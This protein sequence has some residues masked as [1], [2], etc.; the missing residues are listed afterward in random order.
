L[1]LAEECFLSRETIRRLYFE[2]KNEPRFSGLAVQTGPTTI[3]D[4]GPSQAPSLLKDGG[5]SVQAGPFN[6]RIESVRDKS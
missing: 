1:Q 5:V 6:L 2:A 4:E 3:Q